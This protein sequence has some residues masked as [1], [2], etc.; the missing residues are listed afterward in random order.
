MNKTNRLIISL[1]FLLPTALL[2]QI[3]TE[4]F[5]YN[6]KWETCDSLN[7]MHVMLFLYTDT[8]NNIGSIKTTLISGQLESECQY[9]NLKL[10]KKE[11]VSISYHKNGNLKSIINYSED[12]FHGEL[13]TYYSNGK[14]KRKDRYVN[15]ILISGNCFSIDG[16]DTTYYNYE[17]KPQYIGGDTAMMKFVSSNVIYPEKAKRKGI[18]GKVFV[19][20]IINTNGDVEDPI[21]LKSVDPLLDDEAIRAVKLMGKWTPGYKDGE[22]VRVSFQLPINFQL[23]E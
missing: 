23:F 4:K 21:I 6:D 5:F 19:Q 15:G 13:T 12:R 22:K 9:S 1:L 7:A 16:K 18:T 3:K 8:L 20:F 2:G 17:I 14:L 11:G 10:K